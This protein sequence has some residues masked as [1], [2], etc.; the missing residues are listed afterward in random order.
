MCNFIQINI[1]SIERNILIIESKIRPILENG[2]AIMVINKKY[3]GEYDKHI[4]QWYKKLIHTRRTSNSTIVRMIMNYD[5]TFQRNCK[6]LLCYY[7][8]M[9]NNPS[10]HRNVRFFKQDIALSHDYHDNQTMKEEIPFTIKYDKCKTH[11]QIYLLLL[12]NTFA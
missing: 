11:T 7:H 6:R 1:E 2:F 9:M 4:N 10:N 12:V 3:Q 5:T 8:R